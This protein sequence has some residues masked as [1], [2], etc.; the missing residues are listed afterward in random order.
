MLISLESGLQAL[1]S[2]GA[3]ASSSPLT[4][5]VIYD[6]LHDL[7]QHLLALIPTL[8]TTLQL[9]L[10]RNFPHKRQSLVAQA[11][12]IR[13][14]L[15]ISDYCPEVADKILSTIIDRVIQIDVSPFRYVVSFSSSIIGRNTSRA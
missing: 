14:I 2:V 7:L 4:R 1:D 12:Y 11:T 13:N 9:L 8:P 15:R 5:R 10:L 3:E 6:R